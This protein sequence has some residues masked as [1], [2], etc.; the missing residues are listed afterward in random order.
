[1]ELLAPELQPAW[2]TVVNGTSRGLAIQF[3]GQDYVDKSKAIE[4]NIFLFSANCGAA[5]AFCLTQDGAASWSAL[6]TGV[7]SYTS[8]FGTSQA[9]PEVAGMIALLREAFPMASTA[10]LTARLLYTAD[11]GF[12]LT[13]GVSKLSTATYTNAN[14]TITQ[15][16]S[17]LWGHGFANLQNALAPVG[18]PRSMTASGQRIDLAQL[19][20]TVQVG[21]AFGDADRA[22]AGSTFLSNDMLNGVFVGTLGN[23]VAAL[24]DTSMHDT[25]NAQLLDRGMA[26]VDNGKGLTLALASS[27]GVDGQGARHPHTAFSFRQQVGGSNAVAAGFGFSPDTALG[28]KSRHADLR[29]ASPSDAAMGIPY[30][31]FGNRGQHWAAASNRFGGV[32]FTAPL[33]GKWGLEGNYVTART[34]LTGGDTGLLAELSGLRSEAM[35]FAL[36]GDDV[37][38]RGGHLTVGIS[39]PLRVAAGRGTLNLP[40]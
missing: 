32:A 24:P 3:F 28:F 5:A 39:Q 9:T 16:V 23:T 17:D 22:L 8:Q 35:A 7:A 6:N 12:F 10:D 33:A 27:W 18:T 30:L 36:T 21:R 11:N 13:G 14:G 20:G 4:N 38:A 34:R 31:G 26:T 1:M 37:I 2:I 19:S 15:T 25:V 29:A 40:Q